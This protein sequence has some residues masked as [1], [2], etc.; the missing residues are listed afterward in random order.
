MEALDM[1]EE[2][3]A[4]DAQVEALKT[5][6]DAVRA[7][8]EAAA[9]SA[10][11]ATAE[12]QKRDAERMVETHVSAGRIPQA[13]RGEWVERAVRLGVEEVGAMLSDLSPIVA[14]ASPVGHGGAAA[15]VETVKMNPREAEVARANDMLAR[16]RGL[17][18]A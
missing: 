13:R 1:S 5:E 3:K 4:L 17:K 16:F 10:A 6:L 12:L 15:D 8:L 2:K 7:Q 9:T 14:V 11:T 18:G